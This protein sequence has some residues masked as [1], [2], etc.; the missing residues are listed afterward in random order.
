VSLLAFIEICLLL[1]DAQC[2]LNYPGDSLYHAKLA[3]TLLES[4]DPRDYVRD[5][6]WF[7][8]YVINVRVA[9]AVAFHNLGLFKEARQV[10]Q[11]ASNHANSEYKLAYEGWKPHI[12][13]GQISTLIGNTRFAISEAEGLAH[14]ARKLLEAR[15][16]MLDPLFLFMTQITL[17]RA[18]IQHKNIKKAHKLLN[19]QL[20]MV[21]KTPYLG[22][23]HHTMLLKAYAKLCWVENNKADWEY[24]LRNT[25]SI[26]Q[27]AGLD[28]QL[29]QLQAE[30]GET[31]LA[32]I[33]PSSS[34][35]AAF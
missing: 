34:E 32:S 17:G 29:K 23:L 22:P 9:E 14:Q 4:A 31:E 30:Y 1:H 13:R 24:F 12:Y 3:H 10:Y 35:E 18:Y 8:H 20:D 5:R 7:D 19:M 27:G 6:E 15:A 33:L 16:D 11:Q 28:H 26:A 25:I 21:D 2:V